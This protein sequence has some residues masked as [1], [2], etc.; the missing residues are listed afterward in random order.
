[1]KRLLIL[2]L[3][4]SSVGALGQTIPTTPNLGLQLIPDGYANWG[5][6]YR[7]T[8]NTIDAKVAP[9]ASP[10][11]T[12]T[13]TAVNLTV[14]GICTGC[15]S[16]GGMTWPVLAGIPN[17]SGSSSWGT[18][19]SSSNQIPANF[20]PTLNQNT[21]GTAANL[22]GTPALP[23]G[24]TATTQTTGD[25]TTKLATDAFVLANAY[26]LP[27]A[28]TTVLGGVKPDGTTC[29]TTAGV[30]TCP[31]TGGISG[32]T[33]GYIP[34]ATSATAIGNSHM[35]DG[36]TTAS[37]ITSTE[38][39]VAPSFTT[40]GTTPGKFSLVSGTGSIPTLEA[41]SAG[42]AAPVTGGTAYLYKLP[43]TAVAGILHVAAPGTVDGVNESALTSGPVSLTTDVSGALPNANIANPSTTVN[44]MTCTLGSTCSITASVTFPW[45]CQ[46]GLGDGLNAITAGTYPQTSCYNDTGQT[47]TLTGIKCYA[48]AGT[49]TMNVTNSA[50]T[51]LLTGAVTC[52]SSYASGTQSAT[53]TLAAGDYLKFTY[54]AGGTAKQATFVV[55]GTHP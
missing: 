18:S 29:T 4:I 8:M 32:L 47:V 42:F 7:T 25:A 24:T 13:T 3:A 41:N 34:M 38:P 35:D 46:P 45:S 19:Y 26:I 17:Y 30:L 1:M 53:V 50:S 14:T 22:S 12:G 15:G 11:L 54:V 20:I 55:T 16:G 49:P 5:V 2:A 40:L 31:G 28:T 48:D 44:G 21:T 43:A 9:L 6:P 23:N 37:T 33:T 27:Q 36:I 52:S 39:M 10:H 51:A